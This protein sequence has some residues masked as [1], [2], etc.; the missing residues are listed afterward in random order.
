MA[1]RYFQKVLA[2]T[3]FGR[4]DSSGNVN[5]KKLYFLDVVFRP[6]R[7]HYAEFIFAKM[8]E[9]VMVST[10]LIAIKGLI[11]SLAIT[12]GLENEV[13]TLEPI[14]VS[15]PL[16]IDSCLAQKLIKVKGQ[17]EYFL[18]IRNQEARSVVFPNMDHI[19]V[20]DEENWLFYLD[21][22]EVTD[23]LP[24]QFVHVTD[25]LP[26]SSVRVTD[27]PEGANTDEEY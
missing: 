9:I 1:I 8:Q 17:N 20:L 24:T 23:G 19:N 22:P 25:G 21:A 27:T 18:M 12:M 13:A 2:Q 16:D 7:A 4:G 26:T 5:P 15:W 6:R 3:I 14:R 11:T 10:S